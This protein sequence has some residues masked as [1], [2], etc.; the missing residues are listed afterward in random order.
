[1]STLIRCLDMIYL[2]KKTMRTAEQRKLFSTHAIGL[3]EQL[4]GFKL[5]RR[6]F[7]RTKKQ[8]KL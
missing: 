6:T 1:M 5:T 4:F 2:N 3:I 7:H 8:T